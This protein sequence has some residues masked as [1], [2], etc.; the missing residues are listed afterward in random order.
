L[1]ACYLAAWCDWLLGYEELASKWTTLKALSI[2]LHDFRQNKRA[3]AQ[4]EKNNQQ[5]DEELLQEGKWLTKEELQHLYQRLLH[6]LG[7]M[8]GNDITAKKAEKYQYDLFTLCTFAIGGQRLELLLSFRIDNI[9]QL[10]NGDYVLR[11]PREKVVRSNLSAQ[12]AIPQYLGKLLFFYRDKIRPVLLKRRDVLSYWINRKGNPMEAKTFHDHLVRNVQF[13]L[14]D[15]SKKVGSRDF[16]R[17]LPTLIFENDVA[18]MGEEPETYLASYASL[19]NTSPKVLK[20]HYIRKKSNPKQAKVLAAVEE[21][22]LDTPVAIEL[23]RKIMDEG[24]DTDVAPKKKRK[25]VKPA[26][27]GKGL[28]EEN[29][30]LKKLLKKHKIKY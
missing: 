15:P 13:H 1:K 8:D 11:P 19:V 17:L 25:I 22:I 27:D 10:P 14:K 21:H 28:Q 3:L 5:T 6:S 2:F 23:K 12:V 7:D 16:R 26:M 29:I 18:I 4:V 9:I 30:K 24:A 20:S